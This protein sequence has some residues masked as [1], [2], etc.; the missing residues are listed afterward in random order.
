MQARTVL[1]S[2][3]VVAALLISGCGS[4]H[5]YNEPEDPAKDAAAIAE[6]PRPA[7]K[8]PSRKKI[9]KPPGPPVTKAVVGIQPVQ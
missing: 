6:G 3:A 8:A 1:L 2:L 5:T 4:Q 7:R 9:N